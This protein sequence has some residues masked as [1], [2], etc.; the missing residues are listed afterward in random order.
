MSRDYA[1]PGGALA[2]FALNRDDVL[3]Q[4]G[5]EVFGARATGSAVKTK[6]RT[7]ARA[8][9]K[10]TSFIWCTWSGVPGA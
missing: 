7:N 8:P 6:A 2:Q 5:T 3:I 4:P 9:V 10:P 1:V